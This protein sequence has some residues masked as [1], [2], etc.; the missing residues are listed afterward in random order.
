MYTKIYMEQ[1]WND[2]DRRKMN[3]WEKTMSQCYFV[4]HK[5]HPA[6]SGIEPGLSRS[7]AGD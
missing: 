5:F 2:T 6:K 3:Y 4:R 1:W 7:E